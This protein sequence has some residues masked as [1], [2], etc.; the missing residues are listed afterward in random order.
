MLEDMTIDSR[1]E[2]LGHSQGGGNLQMN[3]AGMK[4]MTPGQI[5]RL[6]KD[7]CILFLKG[8]RPIYDKKNWSFTTESFK[9]AERIAG[10]N[11]YKNPVYVTYDE[12]NKKYITT[13]FESRLN[14]I[15]QKKMI[16]FRLSKWM[17]KHFY[18]LT[19]TK[20]R[21]QVYGN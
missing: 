3:K 4:L 5:S 17:K 8:E 6:P 15:N 12:N 19:L 20:L 18:I 13:R 14:Y 21:S 1:S 10:E 2:N 7:D 11:G 9:E 16:V